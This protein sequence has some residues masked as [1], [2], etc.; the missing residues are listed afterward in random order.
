VMFR[1]EASP[2]GQRPQPRLSLRH[3][4]DAVLHRQTGSDLPASSLHWPGATPAAPGD[5][6]SR[7]DVCTSRSTWSTQL[8]GRWR[9]RPAR[10]TWRHPTS[11]PSSCNRLD[12]ARS[13]PSLPTV[14]CATRWRC[15][16]RMP[17]P[18]ARRRSSGTSSGLP[19]P[20]HR[21]GASPI[22]AG[23][24]GQTCTGRCSCTRHYPASRSCRQCA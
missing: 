17:H 11:R 18:R 22:D 20:R 7:F 8:A 4:G 23:A 14:R 13:A 6:Q 19:P 2:E 10:C 12:V 21:P 9:C 24:Y 15:R 16:Y 3:V 5:G 1:P